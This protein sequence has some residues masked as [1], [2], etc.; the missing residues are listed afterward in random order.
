MKT[1]FLAL[2]LCAA[3]P[4]AGYTETA[5]TGFSPRFGV[6][7][8]N[9]DDPDYHQP[10]RPPSRFDIGVE[11]DPFGYRGRDNCRDRHNC[12]PRRDRD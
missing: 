4:A 7:P 5:V 11:I 6:S 2:L 9:P 3:L 12:R 1:L 8:G 10:A